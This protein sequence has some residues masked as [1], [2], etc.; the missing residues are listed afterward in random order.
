MFDLRDRCRLDKYPSMSPKKLITWF[1]LLSLCGIAALVTVAAAARDIANDAS[2]DVESVKAAGK[3][4]SLTQ[5]VQ[6]GEWKAANPNLNHTDLAHKALVEFKLKELPG[7][8]TIGKV[9]QAFKTNKDLLE[10]NTSYANDKGNSSD[11]QRRLPRHAHWG[12]A[13]S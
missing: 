3:R 12:Q 8:S 6:I 11:G 5:K 10:T 9:V 4:Q 2:D 1:L 7:K 13:S